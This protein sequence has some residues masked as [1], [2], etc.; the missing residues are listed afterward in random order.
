VGVE[1]VG[2]STWDQAKAAGIA[3]RDRKPNHKQDE[4]CDLKG[5]WVNFYTDCHKDDIFATN[6]TQKALEGKS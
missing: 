1:G 6:W 2:Q 3:G 4:C 5:R